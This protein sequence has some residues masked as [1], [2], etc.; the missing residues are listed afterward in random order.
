MSEIELSSVIFPEWRAVAEE[1]K[2]VIQRQRDTMV[3]S[4][5]AHGGTRADQQ[6]NV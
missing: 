3:S 4:W 2:I 5:F 1:N 6:A